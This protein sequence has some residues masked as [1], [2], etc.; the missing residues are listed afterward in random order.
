MKGIVLAGDSGTA[1]YPLTIGVP[2]QLLPIYNRPMIYYPLETLKMSGIDDILIITTAEQQPAFIKNLGDGSHIGVKLSYAV[3]DEPKG[4]AEALSIGQ[5][6]LNNDSVCLITGDTI[7]T[8]SGL[9]KQIKK[10]I[11]AVE[12][13]GNA[14]I[15]VAYD[16]DPGQYGRVISNGENQVTIVGDS[17][18]R[19]YYSI[20][21][22]YVFPRSAV[23]HVKSITISERGRLEITALSQL[24]QSED[25]LQI[26]KLSNDCIWHDTNTF[27]G[28]LKCALYV[29]DSFPCNHV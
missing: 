8:G 28:I 17:E 29:K 27:D 7:I 9:S 23:K 12:K 13:S 15:F 4:I 2:K 21:G 3:Q 18:N 24:F 6:F 16:T 19:N 11:N 14:T 10:A 26:Q 22:L 25:K 20:T 1:L 5:D